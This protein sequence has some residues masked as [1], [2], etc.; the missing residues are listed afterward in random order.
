MIVRPLIDIRQRDQALRDLMPVVEWLT[1]ADAA[2]ADG[3]QAIG[4][5]HLASA[6]RAFRHIPQNSPAVKAYL[7]W[8]EED[9]YKE[10]KL[11]SE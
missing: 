9:H 10:M 8:L 3:A 1:N 6:L 2:L 11:L 7:R 4:T 5:G